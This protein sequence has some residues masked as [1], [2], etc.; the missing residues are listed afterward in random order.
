[1]P[2]V[3]PGINSQPSKTSNT[4]WPTLLLGKKLTESHAPSHDSFSK[5]DLPENHR[6]IEGDG[7]MATLDHRPD[8]LNIHVD[9]DG[10]VRKVKFG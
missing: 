3:V 7:G 1:M 2:L 6:V 10:T 8:R 9:A 4:D 5:K